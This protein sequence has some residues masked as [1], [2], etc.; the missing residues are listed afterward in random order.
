[1][2]NRSRPAQARPLDRRRF[3]A[4]L[5]A[6]AVLPLGTKSLGS[7]TV[8]APPP[9]APA[10]GAGMIIREK[11]P[12]NLE[13]PFSALDGLLVPNER[14]YVRSHFATPKIDART[15]KLRIEGAV[16][17]PL[18]IGY[19]ELRSLG[20]EKAVALLECAGN[21]RV[22]LTP[23]VKGVAWELGAVGTAEWTGVPLAAV[24][25]RARLKDSAVDIVLEGADS[26]EIKDEPKA[27]RILPFA[28]SLPRAKA[29]RPEILLAYQM[30]GTELPTSH[31]Y[32]VRAVVPGW[33]AMASVKWL[34]RIIALEKPFNGFH[35][36]IDYS[37]W[38]QDH[39]LP[40]LVPITEIQVKSEIAR[41][42]FHEVVP[43]NA[44]YRMHGAAWTGESEISR[45]EVSINGGATWQPARLADKS[46][47][48]AWRLWEY[49]WRTPANRARVTLMSRA[50]D[51]TGRT[52]PLTH[53]HKR[54]SY[55]VNTVLPIEVDVR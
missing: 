27:P 29:L 3:M 19:D 39:G 22:F 51:K 1:M 7:A 46:R 52:Q 2:T 32:P 53:D 50:T 20:R 14:F 44:V 40:T 35:Q 30:N 15:Y 33:Y 23:K 43:A 11:E 37:Y 16:E 54:G 24:L 21:S 4:H 6:A 38:T 17:R 45:V 47:R 49:L 31:G 12:E 25:K 18:E 55:M 26:G 10:D 34:T 8:G 41:P 28:R 36:T 9:S 42:E 5:A 13:F 48:Y